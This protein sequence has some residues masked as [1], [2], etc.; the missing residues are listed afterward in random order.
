MISFY[1]SILGVS[2]LLSSSGRLATSYD[3]YYS[4]FSLCVCFHCSSARP[5]S[6]PFITFYHHKNNFSFYF[7]CIKLC[8]SGSCS[9]T[10]TQ[11]YNMRVQPS[12]RPSLPQEQQKIHRRPA[13]FAIYLAT[14]FCFIFVSIPF[15]YIMYSLSL[16]LKHFPH[17]VASIYSVLLLLISLSSS[18]RIS[19]L[20]NGLGR[21]ENP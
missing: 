9:H 11:L 6:V 18:P 20:R 1:C 14:L 4:L 7:R 2:S 16:T 15:S 21:V 19:R 13:F 12:V 10:R 3:C 8:E 5:R 17:M